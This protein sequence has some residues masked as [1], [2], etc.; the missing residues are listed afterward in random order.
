MSGLKS[1]FSFVRLPS[2][3][4]SN[5]SLPNDKDGK[6]DANNIP[7][8]PKSYMPSSSAHEDI[9]G[10]I[11]GV[12]LVDSVARAGRGGVPDV[13]VACVE[14]LEYHCGNLFTTMFFFRCPKK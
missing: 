5:R 3:P 14:Y 4:S 10:Y 2:N 11:F 9:E 6:D 7:P 8:R 1:L 12:P 13:V